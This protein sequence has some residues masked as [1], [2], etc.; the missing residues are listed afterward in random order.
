[1]S[2]HTSLSRGGIRRCFESRPRAGGDYRVRGCSPRRSK[3]APAA[4]DIFLVG[5]RGAILASERGVASAWRTL[6]VPQA[7][8]VPVLARRVAGALYAWVSDKPT[9]HIDMILPAWSAGSG[10][11]AV[12]RSL[13]PFDFRRFAIGSGRHPPLI[14]LPPA[15]LLRHLADE[16]VFA[17]LCEAALGAFIAENEARIAAMQS[18]RTNLHDMLVDLQALERQIRQDEITSEVV[19]LA[20]GSDARPRSG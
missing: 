20:G 17:E 8:L 19:E 9:P 3:A 18:A 2:D 5:T 1:M 11:V 14:T 16:Y 7:N 12:T 15:V 13:L 4:A 10:V 6:M